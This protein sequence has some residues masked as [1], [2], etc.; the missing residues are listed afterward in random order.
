MKRLTPAT[1]AT[2]GAGLVFGLRPGYGILQSEQ[3]G[4][5]DRTAFVP[6]GCST[7]NGGTGFPL[8]ACIDPE[9]DFPLN[10]VKP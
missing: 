10:E 1:L 5:I 6:T 2:T 9:N 7:S 4:C 3:Q 8:L